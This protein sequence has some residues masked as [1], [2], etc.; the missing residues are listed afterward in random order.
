MD[1]ILGITATAMNHDIARLNAVAHNLANVS[2]TG[3]KRVMPDVFFTQALQR[4]ESAQRQFLVSDARQGALS[5]SGSY[6]DLA[7]EGDAY[8]ELAGPNG[9]THLTRGGSFALD[10]RGRLVSA[11]SG[12]PLLGE[13][14]EIF[15]Q[16]GVFQVDRTGK[17]TQNNQV[18]SYIKLVYPGKDALLEP[19]GEGLYQLARGA[20]EPTGE[21]RLRQGFLEASNV[22]SAKEM[23][24]LIET[25]RHF[26]SMQKMVQGMDAMWEKTLNKLGEF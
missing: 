22:N 7:I 13:G 24:V 26:E 1:D 23:V 15:L 16:P 10:N 9:E 21:A 11:Q 18:L 2:T 14:G 12:L 25:M 17:L 4:A 5:P 6:F 19:L 3:F 20:L 8:F